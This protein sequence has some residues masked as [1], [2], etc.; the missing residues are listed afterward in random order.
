[1]N[2]AGTALVSALLLWMAVRICPE[3]PWAVPGF[4]RAL[5]NKKKPR[6]CPSVFLRATGS[7]IAVT[8]VSGYSTLVTTVKYSMPK[9]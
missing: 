6:M 4:L 7:R 1:M 5:V 8:I 2:E 9:G 3:C